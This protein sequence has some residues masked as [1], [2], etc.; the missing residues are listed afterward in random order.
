MKF[1]LRYFLP[2]ANLLSIAFAIGWMLLNSALIEKNVVDI[3]DIQLRVMNL[4][5][6]VQ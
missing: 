2:L 3:L 5:N 4:E 6:K 1:A